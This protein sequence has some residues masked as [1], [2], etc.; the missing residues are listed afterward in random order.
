VICRV[1]VLAGGMGVVV[2]RQECIRRVSCVLARLN[3]EE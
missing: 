1:A 3:Q 2:E